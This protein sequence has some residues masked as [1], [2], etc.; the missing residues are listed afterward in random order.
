MIIRLKQFYVSF[1]FDIAV[2]IGG[3]HC[4]VTLLLA[5]HMFNVNF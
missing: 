4:F 2:H 3:R 5:D 1:H